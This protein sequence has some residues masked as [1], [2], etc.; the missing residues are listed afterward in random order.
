MWKV[1]IAAVGTIL[2][3]TFCLNPHPHRL[4]PGTPIWCDG[5]CR[6]VNL[7]FPALSPRI[8]LRHSEVNQASD[9]VEARAPGSNS[10]QVH[11]GEAPTI[12]N[13]WQYMIIH[14]NTKCPPDP[15]NKLPVLSWL[16]LIL[17]DRNLPQHGAVPTCKVPDV[18]CYLHR[19][20]DMFGAFWAHDQCG[21]PFHLNMSCPLVDGR[22]SPPRLHS[23]PHPAAKLYWRL[24][25]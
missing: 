20:A 23:Q 4:H 8:S 9:E 12:D 3:A 7:N 18:Q 10:E 24:T 14:D 17:Q 11:L 21:L 25:R 15:A 19:N 2:A 1:T 6:H 16:M 5:W 22:K 13:T